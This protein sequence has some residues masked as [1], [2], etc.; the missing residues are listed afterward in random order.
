VHTAG[1]LALLTA[2]AVPLA[3][4]SLVRGTAR[5]YV[6]APSG[7][8]VRED[9]LR[10]TLAAGAFATA[11]SAVSS[12]K[13]APDDA[14]LR[15]LYRGTV[16]YYAADYDASARALQRAYALTEDRYT[17]SV[18]RGALA[19]ITN[20]RALP[21]VPGDNERLMVHYYGL[22]G[23]LA[24]RD[25]EGAAVEA[26]RL[27]SQLQ[28]F[29]GRRSEQD[30]STRA[31]LRFLTGLVFEAAGERADAEVAFRNARAL[32]GIPA[33]SGAARPSLAA[34]GSAPV[35][36]ALA[37]ARPM[38]PAAGARSGT[39]VVVIEEGYV[40]HRVER[41]LTLSLSDDDVHVFGEGSDDD[42]LRRAEQ[43]GGRWSLRH[44]PGNG[45]FDGDDGPGTGGEIAKMLEVAFPVYQRSYTPFY[46]PIAVGAGSAAARFT[47]AADLSDA[48][49]G[50]F[51]R[52]LVKLFTRAVARAGT[53][54]ALAE[55]ASRE[56]KDEEKVGEEKEGD[57]KKG[58]DKKGKKKRDF[59]M[60]WGKMAVNFAGTMLE[61]ADTRSWHLLPARISVARLEL[62]A[63]RHVLR[64]DTGAA[65]S[66]VALDTVDVRTG[67]TA[68]VTRRLWNGLTNTPQAA[69][70]AAVG[71]R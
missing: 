12:S 53:K 41:S 14:L 28:R 5:S 71:L 10:G 45:A 35:P 46:T 55:L 19:I 49:E 18:S 32:L 37:P 62:P 36:A 21:Y 52:D 11:L 50:D 27:A 57:D 66:G 8:E 40:A 58:D 33:D 44:G 26:R 48:A 51:A 25:M 64:L 67:E 22:Q 69:Q 16:A 56:K 3:G 23:F 65:G 43:M 9:R 54:Y 17:K 29:D 61:R 42:R 70:S 4:C 13:G 63:G 38:S 47:Y 39:V 24:R 59:K 30:R 1:R 6:L 60:D 31:T 68:F 34:G 7:L 2:L 15:E 20:D